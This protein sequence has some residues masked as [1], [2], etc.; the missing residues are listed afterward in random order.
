MIDL[1][2]NNVEVTPNAKNTESIL[3]ANSMMEREKTFNAAY[4]KNNKVATPEESRLR[5]KL[6]PNTMPNSDKIAIRIT[7]GFAVI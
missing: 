6:M 3:N 7:T 2:T 4:P 1:T 5:P